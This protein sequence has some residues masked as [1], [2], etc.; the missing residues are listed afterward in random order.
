MDFA[1]GYKIVTG[2]CSMRTRYRSEELRT[3]L[4]KRVNAQDAPELIYTVRIRP[5]PTES[6]SFVKKEIH[7]R[8][9]LAST[10]CT[11]L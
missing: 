4:T 11:Q 3:A 5:N 10:I 7:R 9:C 2:E 1:Q 8:A 6:I